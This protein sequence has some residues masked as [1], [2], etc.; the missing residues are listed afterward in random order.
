[1]TEDSDRKG[2]SDP[3]WAK[4]LR[5]AH[6][7]EVMIWNMTRAIVIAELPQGLSNKKVTEP[8]DRRSFQLENGRWLN[9]GE[10]RFE[11]IEA[12]R[13]Q[14]LEWM[15][16]KV[17]QQEA[18]RDPLRHADEIKKAADHLFEKL[19]TADYA[20]V[21]SHY[22]DGKWDSD[23]WEVF[24]TSGLYT[25][26]TDYSRF[27]LWCCTHFKDNPIVAI[28]LGEV[29]TGDVRG[30]DDTGWPTVPYKLTLRD[31]TILA[32]NLPFTYDADGAGGHWHALEGIDWHLW[33][34]P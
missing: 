19:R 2:T 5:N 13:A 9:S 6:I 20:E 28:Q 4:I 34:E 10:S 7:R 16:R 3:E 23:F 27:A 14:F 33:P 32:G 17:S 15:N 22:R 11:S 21:L 25:V 29:F 1:M 8:I 31:G 30:P 18:M 24:P 12:A 26:H